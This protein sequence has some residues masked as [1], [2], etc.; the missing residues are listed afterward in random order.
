MQEVDGRD[1][2]ADIDLLVDT[3]QS[4]NKAKDFQIISDIIF[5]FIQSF[6][7]FN[8]IVIYK[9]NEKE[10][11]LDV[12]S[13][14]G[15]NTERMK[16]RIPFKIGEGAVGLAAKDK[17]PLL[18]DDVFRSQNIKVRQFYEEDPLIRSF[19]AIPL[20]VGDTIVG[21]L[22]VSCSRPNQYTS[23]DMQMISIIAS[24]AAAFLELNEYI[25]EI[26]MVSAQILE[27]VNSG[28]MVIDSEYRI[29]VFND[30]AEKITQYKAEEVLG[31]KCRI[32]H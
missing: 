24:Q 31:K 10:K 16:K 20:V 9:F 29:L 11:S 21:I 15:S 1:I 14:L 3:M 5:K 17:K 22:S 27:K 32:Y 28:V 30:A 4:I 25:S 13:C 7:S 18:I 12:V 2:K 8:M 6:V 23:Y 19:M 26:E